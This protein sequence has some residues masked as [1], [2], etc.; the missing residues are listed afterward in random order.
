MTNELSEFTGLESGFEYIVIQEVFTES[1]IIKYCQRIKEKFNLITLAWSCELSQEWVLRNYMSVK[2]IL[3]STLMLNS[4]EYSIAKNVRIVEPYL[5]Y[6]CL[7][8][9]SRA[10]LLTMPTEVWHDG[11]LARSAHSRVINVVADAIGL[12]SR[13]VGDSIRALLSKAKDYRELFSY[14]FPAS[15]IEGLLVDERVTIEECQ[16]YSRIMCEIAQLHS[17]I[18]QVSLENNVKEIH[19]LD[20]NFF[21]SFI[22]REYMYKLFDS[23]DSYRLGYICRKIGQPINLYWM[24]TDGLIEDFYGAW[25]PSDEM[26]SDS[27]DELDLFNPDKRWGRLFSPL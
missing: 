9:T 17:E 3:S 15:G 4:L 13:S 2:L 18:L 23:E 16:R 27:I 7:H 22:N 24:I 8:N 6:Y 21:R 10:L 12:F 25:Y 20:I 11:K 14:R 1:E 5:T 19:Q 26:L